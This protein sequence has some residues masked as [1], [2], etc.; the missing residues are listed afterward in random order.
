MQYVNLSGY[1]S[2]SLV[3][4]CGVP[5]GSVLGPLLFLVYVNNLPN[6]SSLSIRMFADDTVLF[7]SRK[8]SQTVQAIV[9]NE[10]HKVS[11]RFCSNKLSLS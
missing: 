10:L 2:N 9:S 11:K 8:N 5:Q 6:A 1:N 7:R 4:K 3:V